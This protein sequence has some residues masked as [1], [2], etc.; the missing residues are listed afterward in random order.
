[1]SFFGDRL[2]HF[3]AHLKENTKDAVLSYIATFPFDYWRKHI[4]ISVQKQDGFIVIADGLREHLVYDME[5][6]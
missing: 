1:M 2:V 5:I 3:N 6:R 4:N